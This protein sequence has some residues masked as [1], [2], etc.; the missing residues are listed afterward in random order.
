MHEK[1]RTA[2]PD[3]PVGRSLLKFAAIATFVLITFTCLVL[4]AL[5]VNRASVPRYINSPWT[6]AIGFLVG[7]IGGPATVFLWIGMLWHAAISEHRSGLSRVAWIIFLIVANWLA[8]LAY[9]FW[10]YRKIEF[11]D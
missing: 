7:T 1:A 4:A 8:A 6:Q 5:L 3:R 9:Y 10:R 2:W 11:R